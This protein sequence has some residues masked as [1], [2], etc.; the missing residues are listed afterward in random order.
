[1]LAALVHLSLSLGEANIYLLTS[2]DDF[3]DATSGVTSSSTTPP[4][5]ALTVFFGACPSPTSG[6]CNPL[7]SPSLSPV[8][9]LPSASNQSVTVTA[10]SDPYFSSVAS[11][12][13]SGSF[14]FSIGESLQGCCQSA[15]GWINT[16][17]PGATITSIVITTGPLVFQP[18]QYGGGGYIWS[19]QSQTS[20]R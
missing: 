4:F 3:A 20:P 12:I 6:D 18:F 1:L 11:A 17:Q 15:G 19:S 7:A 14:D 2:I 9:F 8:A 10:A 13:E 16:G 5:S